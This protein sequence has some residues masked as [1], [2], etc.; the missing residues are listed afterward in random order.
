M[1]ICI[2]HPEVQTQAHCLACMKPICQE[3]LV[4]DNGQSFCSAKCAVRQKDSQEV[5]AKEQ[6]RLRRQRRIKLIVRLVILLVGAAVAYIAYGYY[7]QNPD[8]L[9]ELKRTAGE[10]QEAAVNKAAEAIDARKEKEDRKLRE[11]P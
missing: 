8:R 6:T 9:R 1:P 5:I 7:T 2:N 11:E 3:C 10:L 4:V